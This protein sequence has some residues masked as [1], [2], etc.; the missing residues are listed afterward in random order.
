[1]LVIGAGALG[2]PVA[3]VPRRRR[4]SGGWASSTTTPS[5][6]PTCTASCCTSRPTSA[7][8][9][10]ES[11]AAKLRFLNPDVV[12]EPYQMRV[13]ASNAAALVEGQDLVVDCSDAFATR[14]AVNAACCAARVPLVEAGV[15]GH[16]R[17]GDEHQAG[18]DR[19]LPLRVP[20]RAGRRAAL[21]GRRGARPGCGR[22]RLAA[23]AGG[24]EAADGRGAGDRRRVPARR[25]RDGASSCACT[26]RGAPTAPTA[27]GSSIQS[28]MLG[29]PTLRR[30][31]G[32]APAR[33][34][35]RARSRSRRARRVVAGDPRRLAGR[36]GAA[37]APRSR[38]RSASTASRSPRA[39]SRSPRA[40]SRT[41][42]STRARRSAT[43]CSSTTAPA[44]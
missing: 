17:A 5:S 8:P 6:C 2:A 10:A 1:M 3:L 16:V 21:R 25:P 33:R 13:E 41:S 36:A 26:R 40:R 44:S 12:V 27:P 39:C 15:L 19:L 42:R 38:T 14:Y 20:E 9:K 30:V 18:P 43:G 31:A 37:R 7:T 28:R 32:R 24:D 34:R 11:A 35:R 29:L 22:D 4:A 23:G